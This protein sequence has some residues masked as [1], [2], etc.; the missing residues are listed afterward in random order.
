MEILFESRFQKD[1]KKIK[2]KKI[3]QKAKEVILQCK[4]AGQLNEINNLKKMQGY[5]TFYRIRLSDYRM[6]IELSENTL[7]FTRFLHRKEIYR[8]FP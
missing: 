2:D 8:F 6:G 5:Q 4:Q 3:R 1:L 7:I